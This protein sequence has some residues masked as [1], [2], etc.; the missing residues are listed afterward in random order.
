VCLW[1]F[2]G[3][4]GGARVIS[5]GGGMVDGGDSGGRGVV[6]VVDVDSRVESGCRC[7]WVSGRERVEKGRTSEGRRRTRRSS[8]FLVRRTAPPP[9]TD[10]SVG[11]ATPPSSA[12]C[13]AGGRPTNYAASGQAWLDRRVGKIYSILAEFSGIWASGHPFHRALQ[14]VRYGEIRCVAAHAA[15]VRPRNYRPTGKGSDGVGK[16]SWRM[17]V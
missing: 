9:T 16:R 15:V 17:P 13:W 8:G 3:V 7:L 6:G 12:L 1:V 5:G 11:P 14:S 10:G 2:V 4:V